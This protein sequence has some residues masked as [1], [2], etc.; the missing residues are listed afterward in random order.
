MD[1]YNFVFFLEDFFEYNKVI[2]TEIG[3]RQNV[4]SV[5]GFYPENKILRI[6]FQ[7]QHSKTTNKYFSLPFKSLW[8][9]TYF[10]NDFADSTKPIVFIFDARWLEYDY[11]REYAVWLRKKFPSCK[12]VA[13]YI[14]IVATWEDSAKPDAI[15]NLVDLL[16][17]YDKDDAKKYNML[18]HPTV[19]SEAKISE[20]N[21]TPM[22]D[23]FF[24]GAAKN[25]MQKILYAYDVLE[26]AGLNCYFYVM[27]AKPP[28]N[29]KRQGIHYVDKDEW[30]PY[31]KCIQFVQH[32]KCVLEIMQQGAKGETLRVWEAITYGKMLLTNNQSIKESKFYSLDYVSVISENGDIDVERIKK[33]ESRPN[34]FKDQ[35]TPENFLKYIVEKL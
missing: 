35:I 29:Q 3:K 28:Y 31:E 22:T 32:T 21:N 30:L 1:K 13:N 18:C 19:Y 24:V 34:P 9:N 6:L 7:L 12:L 33:F 2:Y 15:R 26:K 27:D 16:V 8:F 11:M 5:F 10:K 14:D 20:L 23:V 17:T 25:R 4:R